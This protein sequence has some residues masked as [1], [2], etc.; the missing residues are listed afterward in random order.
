VEL[1]QEEQ[2]KAGRGQS[3]IIAPRIGVNLFSKSTCNNSF[4]IKID[5]SQNYEKSNDLS[6]WKGHKLLLL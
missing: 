3:K 5:V 4:S 1:S 6:Y 2:K